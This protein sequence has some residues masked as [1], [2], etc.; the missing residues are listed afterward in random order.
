VAP[1][2]GLGFLTGQGI[3]EGET[4]LQRLQPFG[5]ARTIGQQLSSQRVEP[6]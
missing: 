3:G 1:W 6:A 5:D 2:E 4:R